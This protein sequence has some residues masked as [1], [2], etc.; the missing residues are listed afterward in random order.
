MRYEP[1]P[2]AVIRDQKVTILCGFTIHT[3]KYIKANRPDIVIKERLQT[4]NCFLIDMTKL[5]NKNISVK[6]C[7]KRNI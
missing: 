4:K 1:D 5:S 7:D 2:K 6:E 3:G